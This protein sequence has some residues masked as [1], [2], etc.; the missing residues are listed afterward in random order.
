MR[1]RVRMRRRSHQLSRPLFPDDVAVAA[2]MH[3]PHSAPWPLPRRRRSRH[4]SSLAMA[5][6][7]NRPR[8]RE[9][10]SISSSSFLIAEISA[11]HKGSFKRAINLVRLAARAGFDAI[12]L[13]T[14]DPNLIT[15]NSKKRDFL[16]S[17]KKSIW[18]KKR[19]YD[20]YKKGYTQKA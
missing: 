13:Q 6:P 3:L 2:L 9:P 11:N 7:I 8:R 19:L 5:E 10:S 12:K 16:I 20:L 17:D 4:P 18:N 14:Y 1:M 15:L